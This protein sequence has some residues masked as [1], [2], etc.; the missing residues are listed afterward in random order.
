MTAIRSPSTTKCPDKS[1]RHLMSDTKPNRTNLL[2]QGGKGLPSIWTPKTTARARGALNAAD[3][4]ASTAA[5]AFTTGNAMSIS[6]GASRIHLQHLQ[7]ANPTVRS[8]AGSVQLNLFGILGRSN[9][10]GC[11]LRAARESAAI[12]TD[13]SARPSTRD[14]DLI[15][16]SSGKIQQTIHPSEARASLPRERRNQPQVRVGSP[17]PAVRT[18]T[19]PPRW[20]ASLQRKGG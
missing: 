10:A 1:H 18:T 7:S 11:P 2:T 4:R 12:C 6:P 15:G 9:A 20:R 8:I 3:T 13:W 5:V 14:S 17:P 16:S 19:I